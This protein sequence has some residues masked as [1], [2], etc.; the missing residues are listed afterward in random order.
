MCTTSRQTSLTCHHDDIC[1]NAFAGSGEDAVSQDLRP[2]IWLYYVSD[3]ALQ[4]SFT[5]SAHELH[6]RRHLM[7][8]HGSIVVA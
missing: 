7:P 3:M 8:C 4:Q 5:I 2:A 6:D 1:W